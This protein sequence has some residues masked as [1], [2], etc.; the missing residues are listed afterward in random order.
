MTFIKTINILPRWII[1]CLDGIILL[2]S[3]FFAYIIR[4]NFEWSTLEDYYVVEGSVLFLFS[5]LLVM[6]FTKSYV[7]IVRHT[8][9]RDGES[10]FKT[11]VF[12]AILVGLINFVSVQYFGTVNIIPNSVVIIASL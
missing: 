12:N 10:L 9:L 3:A 2:Q 1:A 7:G 5:G 8:R 4:L 11:I 6:F